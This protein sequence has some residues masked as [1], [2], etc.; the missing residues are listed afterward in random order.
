MGAEAQLQ[1]QAGNQAGMLDA[2]G[3]LL[4]FR[5]QDRT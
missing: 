3:K 2:L 1:Q 4:T 5:I